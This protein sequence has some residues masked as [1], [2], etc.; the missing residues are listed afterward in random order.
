[1]CVDAWASI[2]A[3]GRWVAHLQDK[4][5]GLVATEAVAELDDRDLAH[6]HD[7]TVGTLEHVP[8]GVERESGDVRHANNALGQRVGKLGRWR[9]GGEALLHCAAVVRR[10]QWEALYRWHQHR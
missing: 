1:M 10:R 5:L 6:G 4:R 7:G 8:L 9:C 3:R 2:G